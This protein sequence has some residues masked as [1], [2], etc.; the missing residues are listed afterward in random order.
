MRIVTWNIN[1]YRAIL[2]KGFTEWLQDAQP[3]ILCL[4]EIKSTPEQLTDEQKTHSGYEIIWNPAQKLGYSGVATFYKTSLH[5]YQIGM[6]IDRFDFE[7]RVIQT[8]H[9]GFRLFN[10]YFPNGQR[11][12]DRVDYKLEFYRDL[13]SIVDD[14]RSKGE[15]V[16]VTGDFNTAHKEIDLAN[17]KENQKTSGFLPEERV[18]VDEYLKHGMVDIFRIKYPDKVQYTWWTYITNAR[19]RNVGWRIDYYL[20]TPGLVER[21]EDV[22]IH[23]EA[24]GS[25]HCPVELILSE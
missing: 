4:Q 8:R 14:L 25:D 20:I 13:L 1:G 24:M 16:I 9:D 22:I 23:D 2:K 5:D 6:G 17:P 3:D 12:Q 19:A 21:I 11:G 7:G 10:V 18:W 15:E